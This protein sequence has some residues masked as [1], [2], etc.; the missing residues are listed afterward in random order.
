MRPERKCERMFFHGVS[1]LSGAIK[2]PKK[3]HK[4]TKIA[5]KRKKV[6]KKK[7]FS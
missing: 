1:A 5:E 3:I 4:F 6:K 2:R 7:N